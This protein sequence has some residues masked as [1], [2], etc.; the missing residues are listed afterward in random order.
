MKKNIRKILIANRGEIA[1]R[2]MKTCRAMGIRSVAVFS[3]ADRGSPYL[4]DADE[5]FHIGPSTARES[6]LNQE[7]ILT[8]ARTSGADAIHPG[9]GFLSENPQFVEAVEK[10]GL[11]FIGPSSASIRTLGDKT[12]ARAIARQIG[13]PVVPGSD[14]S[15]TSPGQALDVARTIG[16]PVLLKAAAGGGGKGMRVVREEG[17]LAA[18]FKMATSEAASSFS[19]DRVYLE[20]YILNPRHVEVQILA[21]AHGNV[22]HLGEREC[23]IQRRHQKII[24]ES[25]SPAMN[26]TLRAGLTKSAVNLAAHVGYTNAGTV[27][28]IVDESGAYF[29]MEVNTRLQVEHPVTEMRTGLDLVREQII[30]AGGGRLSLKQEDVTFDGHSLECRIYAEDSANNFS[31]FIGTIG[32]VLH[33]SGAGI[34]LDT[35]IESG[36]RISAH[37]DPMIS[38]VIT[39]GSSRREALALMAGALDR[40]EIYGVKTNLDLLIWVINHPEF[41]S[42]IFDTNFLGRNY[43]PEMFDRIPAEVAELAAHVA[44]LVHL[45]AEDRVRLCAE[46]HDASWPSRRSDYLR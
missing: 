42:G 37:Y 1:I 17:E 40:Y 23:S 16:F 25:P 33:P 15:I 32:H 6:Y 13:I 45:R 41:S 3:D 30:I 12:S 35:G 9:Y 2:V 20:K 34:R 22:I 27:E 43:R 29:F 28:F 46:V 10:T 39:H 7:K 44:A 11:V 36:S 4:R 21:D 18:A 31:P 5:T 19:D 38:K 26:D 24:E 14:G 8:V